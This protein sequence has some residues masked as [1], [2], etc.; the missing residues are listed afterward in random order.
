MEVSYSKQ[1][2]HCLQWI[3]FECFSQTVEFKRIAEE[4]E[5]DQRDVGQFY[6]R[7]PERREDI[8]FGD[9]SEENRR[10]E[11]ASKQEAE[12]ADEHAKMRDERTLE[13]RND[14]DPPK[15]DPVAAVKND[16]DRRDRNLIRSVQG[17]PLSKMRQYVL[18]YRKYPHEQGGGGD[19]LPRQQNCIDCAVRWA[20]PFG[21]SHASMLMVETGVILPAK[22]NHRGVVDRLG[23]LGS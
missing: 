15:P 17:L 11:R 4:T 9:M 6:G 12:P 16:C 8:Q 10:K 20:K 2:Y 18:E 13:G 22:R 19:G 1:R 23:D 3:W 7:L 21:H 14:F 5:Q